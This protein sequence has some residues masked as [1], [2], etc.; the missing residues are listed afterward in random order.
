MSCTLK[1]LPLKPLT[2]K[3]DGSRFKA[4]F[5]KAERSVTCTCAAAVATIQSQRPQAFRVIRDLQH[6]R[7]CGMGPCSSCIVGLR[8]ES[9]YSVAVGPGWDLGTGGRGFSLPSH[10]Q[11]RLSSGAKK[12]DMHESRRSMRVETSPQ[13]WGT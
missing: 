4:T 13:Q 3:A 1:L 12:Q 8:A 2:L 7:V 5:S 10:S 6:A 11:L 9:L